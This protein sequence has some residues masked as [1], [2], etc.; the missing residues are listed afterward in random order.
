M[1][2]EDM[3]AERDATTKQ[4]KQ[5]E[6][7]ETGVFF[8]CIEIYNLKNDIENPKRTLNDRQ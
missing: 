5:N 4:Q 3:I 7:H 6:H 1:L 8:L 2:R